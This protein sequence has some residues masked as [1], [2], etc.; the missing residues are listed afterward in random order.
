MLRYVHYIFTTLD[1]LGLPDSRYL[2][3]EKYMDLMHVYSKHK[4]ELPHPIY[5]CIFRIEVHFP[6]A[7]LV[8]VNQ[9]KY[10]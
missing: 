3:P 10:I 6:S 2:G 9:C 5:T 8:L 1:F 4:A 7:Y